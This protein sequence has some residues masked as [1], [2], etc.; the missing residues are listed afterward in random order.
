MLVFYRRF[1]PFAV[2][3]EARSFL[4]KFMGDLNRIAFSVGEPSGAGSEL[5]EW[6]SVRFRALRGRIPS[7]ARFYA[8]VGIL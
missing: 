3:M 7:L 2:F 1:V 5:S 4:I 8:P 6:V